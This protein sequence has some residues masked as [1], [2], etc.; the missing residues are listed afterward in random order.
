[1]EVS[2]KQATRL[3]SRSSVVW[4]TVEKQAKVAQ[5]LKKAT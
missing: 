5:L 3:L 2:L 4:Q 1:M